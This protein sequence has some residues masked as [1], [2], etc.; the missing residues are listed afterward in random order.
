MGG[1]LLTTDEAAAHMRINP[2]TL[3]YW[4]KSKQRC[5]PRYL[6][7]HAHAVRYRLADLE[8][9]LESRLVEPAREVRGAK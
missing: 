1:E 7:V 2:A 6:K 5:G 4:R 3:R 8:D 9:Y